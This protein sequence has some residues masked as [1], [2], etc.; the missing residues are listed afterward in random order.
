MELQPTSKFSEYVKQP[1]AIAVILAFCKLLLFIYIG[2]RYGYFRD[3]MYFLACADHLAWGYPDHAPLSVFLA[4][5]SRDI[6]GDSLHAIRLLPELAGALRILITG[7]IVKEFGG[8]HLAMLIACLAVLVAP[9]YLAIDNLMSMNSYESIFWMGCV[10]SYIW[11]IRRED[12][13]YWL[14]FGAFAGLGLMNKHSM[15]FFGASFVAGLLLTRDRR[16]LAMPQ[17]WLAGAI[18]LVIFLPNII[19]QYQNNWATLELLQNVRNSGKNVSVSPVGFFLQ[20]LLMLNPVSALVWFGGLFALLSGSLAK[21]FR[22]LGVTFVLLFILM[23]ALNAKNYYLGP[24]YP[25]LFAA[26][27]VHWEGV[28]SRVKVGRLALYVYVLLILVS[29]V[30]LAPLAA[31][32]LPVEKYNEYVDTIGVAPPKT[33]VAHEGLLPQ[34][35]GDMFG[36]NEMVAK[37]AIVYDSLPEEERE[38][39]AILAGNYGDAGAIDLFGSSYGLPGAISPHQSYYLWGYG[40]FDGGT[41]ILLDFDKDY[42]EK[43]CGSVEEREAVGEKYSMKY[44][45]FTILVCRDLK[46]PLPQLWKR[47]KHWN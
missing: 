20:Q 45:N 28:S 41:A 36:W 12:P 44:E 42:A 16:N 5:I 2:N 6:F 15:L 40:D 39:T 43:M 31:P 9:G 11:A 35:F 13:N 18:A 34:H 37:T 38:R 24:I 29:G 46:E 10:L 32:I 25:F 33:E 23:A 22:A 47:L 17:F 30:I 14:M 1:I 7:L 27:G 21:K 3:E 4:K 26:G 8:K 19:W